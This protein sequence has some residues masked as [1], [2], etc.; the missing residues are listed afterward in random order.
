MVFALFCVIAQGTCYL[1]ALE[2]FAYILRHYS[3]GFGNGTYIALSIVYGR[4]NDTVDIR[5]LDITVCRVVF[6]GFI[7]FVIVSRPRRTKSKI[8]TTDIR[9]ITKLICS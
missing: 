8:I 1:S 3:S 2:G 9:P 7:G 4:G 6:I 5:A